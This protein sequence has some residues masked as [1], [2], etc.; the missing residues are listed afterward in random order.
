MGEVSFASMI[1]HRECVHPQVDGLDSG[2]PAG[3]GP[4]IILSSLDQPATNG[5][6]VDVLNHQFECRHVRDIS[7]VTASGLPEAMPD[8]GSLGDGDF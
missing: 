7:I 8:S 2:V 4:C 3:A 1:Q 6:L 5:V